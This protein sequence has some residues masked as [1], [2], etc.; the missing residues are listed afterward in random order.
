[1]SL[2]LAIVENHQI[3]REGLR[4]LLR[5]QNDFN[6]VG[7][8]PDGAEALRLVERV[9]PDVLIL[10]LMLPGLNGFEVAK[11]VTDR[12]PATRVVMLTFHADTAYVAQAIRSGAIGYVLKEEGAKELIRAIRLAAAGQRYVSPAISEEAL[13]AFEKGSVDGQANPLHALSMREREVLQLTVDGLSCG[14]ISEILFISPRTVE[15]HRAN[16]M[17]KLKVRNQKEAVSL[18]VARGW[19]VPGSSR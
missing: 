16:L 10:D 18:A 12:F 19:V 1:M 8:A 11:W 9:R 5:G 15:S 6:V 2:S 14:E 17:R 4:A 13:H 7:E 3:V